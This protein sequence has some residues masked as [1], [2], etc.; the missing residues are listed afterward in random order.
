MICPGTQPA[1]NDGIYKDV[2]FEEYRSWQAWNM[3]TIHHATRTLNRVRYEC[4]HSTDISA[5]PKGTL[6]H[7]CMLE[8][9]EIFERYMPMPATYPVVS[10]AEGADGSVKVDGMAYVYGVGRGAARTTRLIVP[11]W[12]DGKNAWVCENLP[13]ECVLTESTWNST[14]NWCKAW[15]ERH[16][17]DKEMVKDDDLNQMIHRSQRM[18][19]L[20][21]VQRLFDGADTEVSIVWT[22]PNTGLRCKARLDLLNMTLNARIGDAK[23]TA[24]SASFERYLSTMRRYGYVDQAA[25]YR[26]GLDIILGDK[27][28]ATEVSG[29]TWLVSEDEPPHDPAVYTILDCGDIGSGPFFLHGRARYRQW[30]HQIAEAIK[31]NYWPGHNPGPGGLTDEMELMP[32]EWWAL[33]GMVEV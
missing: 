26:D 11:T 7:V 29:F 5:G 17:G 4:D 27:R 28:P 32:A 12:D 20:P 30:L 10:K 13:A 24:Y 31:E 15:T 22:C 14:A 1:P 19:E 3:S 9:D 33:D 25:F 2:P 6:F 21:F 16:A 18:H 23:T 8:P